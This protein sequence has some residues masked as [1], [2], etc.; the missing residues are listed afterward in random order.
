MKT[1]HKIYFKDSSDM[2]EIGSNSID[3]LITSPPYPMIEMWDEIF[4]SANKKIKGL[5]ETGEGLKAFQLMHEQL[6]NIWEESLRMIKKGGI[7]CIN[8][9]DA[10]R[11][12][13]NRFQL[14]PNHV[15]ITNFFQ[16]RDCLVLPIILWRKPTNSPTKFMGSGML[17]SNAYVTLEHEYILIFRKGKKNRRFKPKS[18]KRYKSAYF[19]EERNKWFSDEWSDI[20]GESQNLDNYENLR[21]R[22]GA[23]PVE[24]PYRLINMFSIY[25]DNILDPFWG[26]GTT[27]LAAMISARNSVGYEIETEFSKVFQNNIKKIKKLTESINKERIRNHLKFIKKYTKNKQIKYTSVNYDFPVVT[28][29]EKDIL[30][31]SIEDIKRSDNFY[32]IEHAKFLYNGKNSKKVQSSLIK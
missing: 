24:I 13:G 5:I 14:Y 19:W 23:F 2:S 18:E 30:L 12:I 6:N 22:S 10:T 25:G 7:I 1:E 9:G 26:T 31:Y 28:T 27:T 20:I 11:K 21:A 17:P 4:F 8:I 16:N 32:N 15:N 3:L 29:Q